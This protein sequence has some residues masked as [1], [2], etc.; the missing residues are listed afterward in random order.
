LEGQVSEIHG[1]EE[2]RARQWYGDKFLLVGSLATAPA[3]IV[4]AMAKVHWY[5]LHAER[6]HFIDNSQGFGPRDQIDLGRD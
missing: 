5:R 6:M 1:D 3:A 2:L 4:E